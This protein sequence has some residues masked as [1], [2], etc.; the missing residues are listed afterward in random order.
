MLQREDWLL[1]F[2]GLPGGKFYT[3][4]VRVMKGMFLFSK[5]GP[6]SVRD[7]YDFSP[8]AYGPFDT[9]VYRDLNSLEAQG[10][11]RCSAVFGTNRRVFELSGQGQ[12]RCQQ[13]VKDAP[14]DALDAL[15]GIKE[16]VTSLSFVELLKFVY[17][18]YPDYAARTVMR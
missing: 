7:L 18:K 15:R 8:Y 3:D 11:I 6:T 5:E 14:A 1:L 2:I 10:L 16:R 4:Q 17:G 12:Q 9:A 13:L